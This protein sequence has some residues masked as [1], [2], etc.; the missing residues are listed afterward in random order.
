DQPHEGDA[1]T[2]R[3]DR[4]EGQ[5]DGPGPVEPEPM[6]A[7]EGPEREVDEKQEADAGADKEDAPP[8]K[9]P[10]LESGE[11]AERPKATGKGHHASLR[12]PPPPH[13]GGERPR[14]NTPF[15]A[16][17]RARRPHQPVWDLLRDALYRRPIRKLGSLIV[18]DDR[19]SL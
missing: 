19:E 12:P 1:E 10:S 9:A 11:A 17:E 3:D 14:Q 7:V 13:M 5:G 2:R 4:P 8:L 15:V 16:A 6:E 18:I